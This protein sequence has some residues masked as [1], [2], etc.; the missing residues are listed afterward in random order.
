[1]LP[2]GLELPRPIEPLDKAFGR[3]GILRAGDAVIRPYRRGGWM[4]FLSQGAYASPR[5]FEREWEIHRALWTAGFPTVEPLGY[6][7]RRSGLAWEGLLLTRLQPGVAW[8]GAWE[9][10]RARLPELQQ[11]IDA[12]CV[13]GLWAPDLNA[14]NVLVVADGI[15]LLD[16]DRAAFVPG[17]QLRPL[18]AR[19]MARSLKKLDAPM[20]LREAFGV[21]R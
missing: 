10:G 21:A 1:M 15:R 7:R 13:W 6:G 11:A 12:L 2:E 20:D 4:R 5:R 9:E 17:A 3:G 18:Y 8:P 19:R 14:T 16:W